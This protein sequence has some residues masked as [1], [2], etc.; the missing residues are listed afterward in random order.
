MPLFGCV[1][2]TFIK[3]A[4]NT[5]FG[6]P[7]HV[8]VGKDGTVFVGILADGSSSLR[9]YTYNGS[10]FT[11]TAYINFELGMKG[12][13]VGPDN[14][15]FVATCYD[16]LWA[17]HYDGSSFAKTAHIINSTCVRDIAVGL[18]IPYGV[19]LCAT[20]R[21]LCDQRPCPVFRVCSR[22]MRL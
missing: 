21:G 12:I 8:T 15:V 16:D 22:G 6:S 3:T 18:G 4:Q 20:L 11:N 10:S 5:H 13:A 7:E 2:Q 14:T 17:Y 19:Q 9:A 1:P